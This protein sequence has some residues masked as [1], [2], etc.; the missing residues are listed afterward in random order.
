[1][2][3]Y[4]RMTQITVSDCRD[5]GDGSGPHFQCCQLQAREN[6]FFDKKMRLLEE[7]QHMLIN[8]TQFKI[9]LRH[10]DPNSLNQTIWVKT[11]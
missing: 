4:P 6:G 11:V 3:S 9:T 7:L 5:P 1:M 10:F 2:S 8:I